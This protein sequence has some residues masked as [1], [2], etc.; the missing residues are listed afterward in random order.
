MGAVLP[1]LRR[2]Q[3]AGEA[4]RFR[5]RIAVRLNLRGCRDDRHLTLPHHEHPSDQPQDTAD[6][7]ADHLTPHQAP[8]RVANNLGNFHERLDLGALGKA[9]RLCVPRYAGGTTRE[10]T[11]TPRSTPTR[12]KFNRLFTPEGVATDM[13]SGLNLAP[14][15]SV[16][17]KN[18][19][20]KTSAATLDKLDA[21]DGDDLAVIIET[22]KG[23]QNK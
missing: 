7:S 4:A 13:P 8:R 15:S 22:A 12:T 18:A 16:P 23:S 11:T 21:Y 6:G 1:A 20:G 10:A 17:T 2:V 19:R 9:A 3:Q 14:R 5:S